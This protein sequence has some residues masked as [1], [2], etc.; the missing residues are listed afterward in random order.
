MD[1]SAKFMLIFDRKNYI[2]YFFADEREDD[3]LDCVAP[4]HFFF[5]GGKYYYHFLKD[6]ATSEVGDLVGDKYTFTRGD[7]RWISLDGESL[8]VKQGRNFRIHKRRYY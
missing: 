7:K 2:R 8:A 4:E 1:E 5:H 6:G 3:I